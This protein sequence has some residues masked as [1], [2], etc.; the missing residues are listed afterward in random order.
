[1]KKIKLYLFF[2][3]AILSLLGCEN[4]E[5][6]VASA[7]NDEFVVT[8]DA[9]HGIDTDGKCAYNNPFHLNDLQFIFFIKLYS[10]HQ[11]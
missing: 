4:I 5:K 7:I 3:I 11:N 8:I 9:G 1:M 6:N 2:F 10:H